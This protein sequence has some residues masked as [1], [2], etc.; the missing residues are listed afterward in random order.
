MNAAQ[1]R[2]SIRLVSPVLSGITLALLALL[3]SACGNQATESET[4]QEPVEDAT[5]IAEN[6]DPPAAQTEADL[7]AQRFGEQLTVTGEVATIY[8]ER[9]FRL[10][11]DEYFTETGVLVINGSADL[12]NVNDGDSVQVV[13]E[14][15][16]LAIADLEQKYELV[17]DPAAKQEL[18]AYA[19][20][21]VILAEV[22]NPVEP[23]STP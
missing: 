22:I 8:G 1:N 20:E 13:G 17:L 7:A 11:D 9:T 18:E 6:P 16:P 5:A 2:V 23:I 15:Q 21:P 10:Q 14:V 19:G 4:V 12:L 3:L